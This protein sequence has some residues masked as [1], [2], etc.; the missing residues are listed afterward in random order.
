M[1]IET[2]KLSEPIIQ[3]RF[4]ETAKALIETLKEHLRAVLREPRNI[5]ELHR[6]RGFS[7]AALHS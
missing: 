4:K 6:L 5:D 7:E 1:P 3:K 2:R